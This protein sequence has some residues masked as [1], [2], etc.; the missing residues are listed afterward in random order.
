MDIQQYIRDTNKGF[1]PVFVED[2]F[3]KKTQEQLLADWSA[4]IN[5]DID[6][7][8]RDS[9]LEGMRRKSVRP[10]TWLR[11][12][13]IGTGLYPDIEDPDFAS[14]LYKKTEF[15]SLASV[16]APEETCF[17]QSRS[18]FETTPVQRL[19]ARFLHPST[20]YNGILL[21]H[22]VGVG[23]TCSAIT[24]AETFLEYMPTHTVFIIA[25]QA[26]ASGFRKTIFDVNRLTAASKEHTR[27]TGDKW[28]S[29]QCTGMNYLRLTGTASEESRDVVAK[30][31]DKVIRKRY[32][33]MGYLAF[34]NWV[35]RKLAAAVPPT[36]TGPA[37]EREENAVLLHMFSDHLI[38]IDE[39]HNL[40]DSESGDADE[41]DESLVNDAAA[42]K[43]LTPIIKRIVGIAEGLRLMLMTATPMYNTAPEITFLLDLLLLNDTKDFKRLLG[44]T[45][46]KRDGSLIPEKKDELVKVIKRYV[47]YMRGENPNT[48]PLR[49]TPPETNIEAVVQDYPTTSISRAEGT[50]IITDLQKNIMKAL[51]LVVTPVSQDTI[52]GSLLQAKLSTNAMTAAEREE[53]GEGVSNFVLDEIMQIGNITYPNRTWGSTGLTTF[54][55]TSTTTIKGTKC[56]QYSWKEGKLEDGSQSPPFD[57]VFGEGLFR[58]A[59]KIA[60][61]VDSILSGK[62]MSFVYSRYVKAGAIPIAIALEARGLCRCLADGTPAPLLKKAAVGGYKG[63][64]ILLTSD[65]EASPNFKGLLEYATT[66]TSA[67]EADGRKVK[68]IIG[69]T[70]ASEGLDLKC[71]RQ[72]HLLD[73]WYHLNRIEQITGR[74]V[75]FCSHSLLSAEERNCLVYLHAVSIPTFETSD[76]YAYRLAV[77]KAIPIGIVSKLMKTNAWDCMLN[78]DAIMLKELPSRRIIDSH[79]KVTEEYELKDKP[80]T[81]FCDYEKTCELIC[82]SKPVP[83][84]EVGADKST[85][86]EFDFRRLFLEKQALLAGIFSTEV[87]EPF[88]KIKNIVYGDIP[89]SI[90]AIGL[91]EALGTIRIQ[92]EDGLYGTLV[93]QNDYIVFQPDGV[94]DTA[95]P[96]ALRYGRAYGR[97]PR[98]IVPSR[99]SVFSYA[100]PVALDAEA[101]VEE[102]HVAT[103]V[104]PQAELAK[105]A[106]DSLALWRKSLDEILTKPTG[107]ISIPVGFKEETFNGLR[108]VYNHFAELEDTVPIAL[109]WWTDNVWT[110]EERAAVLS[111]FVRRDE[112]ERDDAMIANLFRPVELFQGAVKGFFEYKDG[113]VKPHCLIEGES[114]PALCPTSFLSTVENL[115]GQ[116]VDRRADTDDVFGMLINKSG[117]TI[118]KTVD[119]TAGKVLKLEGAECANQSNLKNHEAR[120]MNVHKK[121]KEAFPADSP[122]VK[123]LLSDEAAGAIEDNKV[124]QGIQDA[125]KKMYNPKLK[126]TD[127][128]LRI[129]HVTHLSL[130][131]IC[132]YMEFLLRW[133]DM[134]RVGGKRWFLSLVD[135]VR[136]GAK[137]GE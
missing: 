28:L 136:A 3:E 73:G 60:K 12:R 104:L 133:M 110:T 23:K 5:P 129:T 117:N 111:D 126:A 41:V 88:D 74:G 94:T 114:V 54:F 112:L 24:V 115:I 42:G 10:Q 67:E 132:P 38:I 61:I 121:I 29:P 4:T 56:L 99:G 97:L 78:I 40:R 18:Y 70:V 30:E 53:E 64:Y 122:M 68:A 58:H 81:S 7:A 55:K 2:I 62:G 123:L 92:R 82:G 102:H 47:S 27:L 83:K 65:Q 39:A 45:V 128:S 103:E 95:V 71:I 35:K 31:V 36:V 49:L 52:V 86:T 25:P 105:R 20:P 91:R 116:P 120:I 127:P 76:L 16:L 13:D 100:A 134:R 69:S 8:V 106:M 96:M 119:K 14:L 125:L 108:W 131:Q 63:Y 90:G 21:N 57:T 137:M 107:P 72:L 75:R 43:A 66:F 33:I 101:A 118:F 85:Y 59:P 46:F 124:R 9:L 34:A 26:I 1:N 17:Q 44:N 87:A 80:Y 84:A 89:W 32:A 113:T 15:A 22:G 6:Y 37:R 77:R 135:A 19:V 50:V 109:K 130:K 98:T 48:F 93:L 79:G 11:E 51:P